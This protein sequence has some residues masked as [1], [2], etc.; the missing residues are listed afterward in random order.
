MC[1][2]PVCGGGLL[3]V[4]ARRLRPQTVTLYNY[5]GTT[6]GVMQFQRTVLGHVALNTAYQQVLSMRG[7]TTADRAQ[8]TVEL[9]DIDANK[10][11]LPYHEWLIKT[12]KTRFFT[13]SQSNDFFVVGDVADELP[14]TTKQQ[15]Q[16]KYQV[17][18]VTSCMTAA[19]DE[20]APSILVVTGK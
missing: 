15:M 1:G 3:K 13:F 18:S 20:A 2:A 14:P 12:D 4:M 17:F 7:V 10:S 19:T 6:A 5:L 8:L 16:G 11:Y 9:R